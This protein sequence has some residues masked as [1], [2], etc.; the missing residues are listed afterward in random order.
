MTYE[1]H[2]ARVMKDAE[3]D[4]DAFAEAVGDFLPPGF[5]TRADIR[6]TK[7][8]WGTQRGRDA[9]IECAREMQRLFRD[10]DGPIGAML[11]KLVTKHAED[12][13]NEED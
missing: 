4:I 7:K 2:L 10:N 1:R 8:Y 12:T 6:D 5:A 9:T 3:L 13:F 11:V